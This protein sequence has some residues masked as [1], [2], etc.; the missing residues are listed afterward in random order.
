MERSKLKEGTITIKLSDENC[1][2]LFRKCGECGL[3][4]RE[5]IEQFINDL[6]E[7][8]WSD[9]ALYLNRWF[10]RCYLG[11]FIEPTLLNHLLYRMYE[12]TRYLELLDNL[13]EAEEDK[14]YLKK[15]HLKG[16]DEE[17]QLIDFLSPLNKIIASCEEEKREMLWLQQEYGK[18]KKD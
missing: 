11:K 7:D 16:V 5:L 13:K 14:V 15:H 4:V 10:E 18:L 17:V 3:T 9:E 2:K 1:E 12:P 6:V 8:S